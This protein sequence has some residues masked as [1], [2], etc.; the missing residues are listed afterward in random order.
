MRDQFFLW[1]KELPVAFV[2][3]RARGCVRAIRHDYTSLLLLRFMGEEAHFNRHNSRPTKRLRQRRR[4]VFQGPPQRDIIF[5]RACFNR[6]VQ[7]EGETADQYIME[8]Y[9]LE[10]SCD[11]GDL[12]DEIIRDRLVVYRNKGH[13]TIRAQSRA[14]A[15]EGEDQDPPEGSSGSAAGRTQRRNATQHV[16]A[17]GPLQEARS[18]KEE[19]LHSPAPFSR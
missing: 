1:S 2:A 6:R 13:C 14:N 4:Q 10:K 7:Q 9:R 3:A 19:N 11:Y 16:G 17:S 18:R 15:G 8:L 5:E 12:R